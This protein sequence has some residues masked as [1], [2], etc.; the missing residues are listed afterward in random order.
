VYDPERGYPTVV[1]CVL[2]D[3]LPQAV[4][5][6][7][8]TLG[9]REMVRATMPD[10]WSGHSEV[11]RDGFV[12]LLGRRG[13]GLDDSAS[14]TQVFV[15]D[16]GKTCELA[17]LGGG[18]I[19]VTPSDRPWGVRQAVVTDPGGHRWVIA[20]HLRDTDPED[21]YGEVFEPVLG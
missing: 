20:Q 13:Q 18:S 10:G 11:E 21:W 4:R 3:D 7:R 5:W 2:Y 19:L 6:L 9:F 17:V 1:P 8:D 15:E 16:V 12:V 14:I